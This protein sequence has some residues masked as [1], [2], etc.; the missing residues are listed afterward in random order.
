MGNFFAAKF[1]SGVLYRIFEQTGNRTALESS[2]VQY[3]KARAVWAE[4]ANLAK[5]SYMSDVTVGE[6]PQQHGHWLDRL[7]AIDRDIAA[8]AERLDGIKRSEP[9]ASVG[10]AIKEV[11]GRPEREILLCRHTPRTRFV[12]GQPLEIDLSLETPAASVILYYRH[13]NQAERFN[14]AAMERREQR[15]R[16]TIPAT[17]TDSVYPLEYYFE[18]KSTTGKTLLYPG[19]GKDLTNQPYFVIRPFHNPSSPTVVIKSESSYE[20]VSE[21]RAVATGSYGNL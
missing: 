9:S 19:F 16:V 8:I 15:C 12:P 13:V 1:R 2:L 10:L 11:L 3:R 14:L 21:P 6:Q 20:Y 5:G 7:P 18:V 17:Y 4:L